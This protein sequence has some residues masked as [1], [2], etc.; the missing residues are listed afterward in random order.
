MEEEKK[1]KKKK[2]KNKTLDAPI[3][4]KMV[5][6]PV[7]KKTIAATALALLLAWRI[8]FGGG[9]EQAI[10]AFSGGWIS[11]TVTYTTVVGAGY[12]TPTDPTL[13]CIEG[14]LYTGQGMADTSVAVYWELVADPWVFYGNNLVSRRQFNATTDSTGYWNVSVYRNP[15]LSDSTSEWRVRIPSINF[16]KMVTVPDTSTIQFQELF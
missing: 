11:G 9:K 7:C 1:G 8:V 12:C 16:E 10:T 6:E 4:D 2:K 14:Y 3:K 15:L 13:C 5:R